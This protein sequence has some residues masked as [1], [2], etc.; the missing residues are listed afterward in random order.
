MLLFKSLQTRLA[1]LL[2]RKICLICLFPTLDKYHCKYVNYINNPDH[3]ATMQCDKSSIV[4][5]LACYLLTIDKRMDIPSLGHDPHVSEP[6]IRFH[7]PFLSL[8][9]LSRQ[10]RSVNLASMSRVE[11][12]I[13]KE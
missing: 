5:E 3:N 7:R 13:I 4:S 1:L 10:A 2:K 6:C 8:V 11:L 9:I 12:K